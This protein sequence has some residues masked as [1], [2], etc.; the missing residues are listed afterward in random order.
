M[1]LHVHVKLTPNPG[2]VSAAFQAQEPVPL[3]QRSHPGPPTAPPGPGPETGHPQ[4]G[5]QPDLSGAPTPS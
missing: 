1:V 5:A 4:C 3:C 2:K